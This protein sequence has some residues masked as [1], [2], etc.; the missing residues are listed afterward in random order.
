M[1]ESFNGQDLERL[2]LMPLNQ[3]ATLKLKEAGVAEREGALP[4]FLLMEW[5]LASG[6]SLTHRRTAQ[7]LLRLSLQS[8]QQAA[9][10]YLLA[11]HPGG[12]RDLLRQLLR[13][14][15]RAASQLL[16]DILDM[17]LKADPR[18]PYPAG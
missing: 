15:P 5:G 16:L 14:P 2:R 11:N 4:V 3:V 9:V 12:V 1:A 6:V 17:R 10:D 18:N 13:L 8:D 7:E